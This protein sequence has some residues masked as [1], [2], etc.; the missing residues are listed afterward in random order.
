[1][2]VILRAGPSD[3][4]APE[5]P[6]ALTDRFEDEVGRVAVAASRVCQPNFVLYKEVDC[7]CFCRHCSRMTGKPEV[8]PRYSNR[9]S[10]SCSSSV[11]IRRL[12]VL[13]LLPN[14]LPRSL[15]G[16]DDK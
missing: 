16:F 12:S 13:V 6:A 2:L 15:L 5:I 14:F 3:E 1:M 9:Q 10:G 11:N 8:I 4:Y 7:R